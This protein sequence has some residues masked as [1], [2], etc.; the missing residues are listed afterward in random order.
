MSAGELGA[1][2]VCA[3][4]RARLGF[5][6]S[7]R[8]VRPHDSSCIIDHPSQSFS[9]VLYAPGMLP[10]TCIVPSQCE[11]IDSNRREKWRSY[12]ETMPDAFWDVRK[13]RLKA[14]Q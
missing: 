12:A 11:R 7:V 4:A 5:V 9:F 1:V 10:L 8:R 2:G 6:N 13:A 14:L 3:R